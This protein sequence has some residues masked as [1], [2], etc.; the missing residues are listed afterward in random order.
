MQEWTTK[1]IVATVFG[2]LN[3]FKSLQ[4]EKMLKLVMDFWYDPA[5]LQKVA[6]AYHKPIQT[7]I[8]F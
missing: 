4:E 8:F 5:I 2:D 3:F 7:V 1:S 6:D